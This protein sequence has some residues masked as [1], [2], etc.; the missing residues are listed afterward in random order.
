MLSPVTEAAWAVLRAARPLAGFTLV[1]GT[2]LTLR[3][4][5]RISEDLDFAWC[6][7]RLPSR[8]IQQALAEAERAGLSWQ[9]HDDPAALAALADSGLELHDYQQDYLVG[10]AKV[11][12][13]APDTGSRRVLSAEREEG[14][15]IATV[16]E[17]FASKALLSARRSRSRDWFD[18]Y[19]LMRDHGCG[20]RDYAK[21]F[22]TAGDRFGFELGLARLCSG[23][24]DRADEGFHA[25]VAEAPS[26][27]QMRAFFVERRDEFE[28]AVTAERVRRS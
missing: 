15:R 4:G 13:F 21:A 11:S 8:R 12:F 10:G 3:I 22:E 17:I 18:L 5:H 9:R 14:P 27:E 25:L 7:D 16:A 28:V 6:E 2:A 1:G 23:R 19:V 24:P 26:V 20:M